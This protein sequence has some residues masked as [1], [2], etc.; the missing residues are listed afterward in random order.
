LWHE[1]PQ[2]RAAA[3][4]R[5][6]IWKLHGVKHRVVEPRTDR[7]CLVPGVSVD[8]PVL[9]RRARD[10]LD[11]AAG[12][13]L[14]Q[15]GLPADLIE[16]LSH[17]VLPDWDEEWLVFE[18]ERIRQLRIHAIEALSDK[19]RILGNH[20]DAVQAGLAAVAADPLRESA[21]RALI[22]A[23]LAEGNAADARRQFETYGK[24]LWADLRVRPSPSLEAIVMTH[25]SNP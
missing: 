10:V 23:H 22:M 5:A 25:R 13:L 12:T 21:Q 6:A 19:L 8:V 18:R 1:I 14:P 3:N 11:H 4:L 17:D 16:G 15:V 24:Q 7:L 20:A 2:Q 9:V